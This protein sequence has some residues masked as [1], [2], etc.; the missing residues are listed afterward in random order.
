MTGRVWII[1]G[2]VAAMIAAAA[3]VSNSAI[4]APDVIYTN[5][6]IATFDPTDRTVQA[7]AIAQGRF[8]AVGSNDEIAKL[9]DGTTRRVDLGGRT[10]VPGLID[11]HSHPTVAMTMIELAVDGRFP[12]VKSVAQ[13]M[14]NLADRAKSTPAG[15]WILV[16]GASASEA[17]YLEKRVPT[18]AELDAAAPGHPVVFFNGTHEFVASS[19]ALAQMGAQKGATSLPR[20]GVVALDREGNPTGELFEAGNSIPDLVTAADLVRFFSKDIPALWGSYGFTTI[21]SILALPELA[22]LNRYAQSNAAKPNLRYV[23]SVYSDPAGLNMPPN[24]DQVRVVAVADPTYFR[25]GGVKAWID[26]EADARSG[27]LYEPYV[28]YDPNKPSPTDFEGGKG[29]LVTPPDQAQS[30]ASRANA[31][32]LITML[33]TSGDRSM[34]IALDAYDAARRGQTAPA[35]MRIEHFGMFMLRPDQLQRAK[36]LGLRIGVQ[37]A[38][39]NFL[40]RADHELLGSARADTAFRFR[41]MIDGGLEPAAGSDMTGIYIDAVNPFVHIWAAVT[42]ESDMGVLQP[43]QAVTVVEA[44]KMWTIWAARAIGWDNHVGSIEVG[45]LADMTV[46][47]DDIFTIPPT[48]LRDVKAGSTILG[49][50]IVYTSGPR[51]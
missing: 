3:V 43:D 36:A 30:L 13:A 42:R 51:L 21:M 35:I 17:K 14:A 47:T 26:G 44:V 24:L 9:A 50:A 32:G 12:G 49:G 41:A 25:T 29:L 31:A 23:T 18:K 11:S 28:G 33:H 8:V 5:G 22:V 37:P 46:L 1:F 45:K 48:R 4:A 6:R 7:V 40:G 39:I 20:G 15:A 19:A 38:W 34:D 16:V 10:V 2:I 27:L